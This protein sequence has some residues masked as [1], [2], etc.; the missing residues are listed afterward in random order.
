MQISE[1]QQELVAA[2]VE[3]EQLKNVKNNQTRKIERLQTSLE[4]Q[5]RE[6]TRL[7]EELLTT[8]KSLDETTLARDKEQV[9][10]LKIVISYI[11]TNVLILADRTKNQNELPTSTVTVCQT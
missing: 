4:S 10:E 6:M 11:Y 8:K 1:T 9:S 3:L 5:Q 2:N 7:Q